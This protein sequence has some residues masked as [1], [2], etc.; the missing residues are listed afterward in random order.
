MRVGVYVLKKKTKNRETNKRQRERKETK[1]KNVKKELYS[2][3]IKIDETLIF[4][5]WCQ[6]VFCVF[7]FG[8]L[9][10][11]YAHISRFSWDEGNSETVILIY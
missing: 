10:R 1:G 4:S 7:V 9:F 3:E 11:N 6:M 8:V 5:F 2:L